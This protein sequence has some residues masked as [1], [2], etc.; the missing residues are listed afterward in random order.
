[1][2]YRIIN[3]CIVTLNNKNEIIK[4]GEVE[5]KDGVI[6][7][8]GN[9]RPNCNI[10]TIDAKGNIIMP[11]F[12]NTH[13]HSPMSLFRGVGEGSDFSTWWVNFMRPL[14]EKLKSEDYY[15]GSMLSIA[16]M[17]RAGITTFADF[18]M[19]P[20]TCLKAV[21]KTKIRAVLGL[22]AFEGQ[23]ENFNQKILEDE[24][25]S[26]KTNSNLV[27]FM[28]ICHAIYS[29]DEDRYGQTIKFCKK[30]DFPFSTHVSETLNEVGECDKKYQM[31]PIAL[32][33]SYGAL[34]VPTILAH[35]VHLDNEDIEI[36]KNY[37]CSISTNSSS[38][39]VLGSGIAPIYSYLKNGLNI[40]IGTD[41]VASNNRFDMFKEMFLTQNLQS[42]S[43]NKADAISSLDVLKFA[44]INGAKALKIKNLGV[45]DKGYMADIIMLDCF[46]PNLTPLNDIYN[47]IV[48]SCGV[49]NVC[50]TI[51]NGEILY[52]NG[53][54]T[55][56]NISEV[57]DNANKSI[58][59]LKKCE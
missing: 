27:S 8:V 58:E 28:G 38:N 21:E 2:N 50:M 34:D 5:I 56:L 33:E 25:K 53:K 44:T 55:T 15:N 42:A 49:D 16:E 18:Y 20:N 35:C 24:L 26:V 54:W 31:T 9:F 32:L 13:C 23:I 22:G 59:T 30:H 7:Y 19:L 11:G 14:E 39:I 45:L 12:V 57:L 36:L 3:A 40:C 51:V 37:D 46:A 43:L 41:S 10:K 29:T 4:N 6:V 48:K 47:I 17:L 1:M 52:E